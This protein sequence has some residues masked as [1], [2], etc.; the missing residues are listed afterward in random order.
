MTSTLS[1]SDIP[2]T[3]VDALHV[4]A[5]NGDDLNRLSF[6]Q[7]TALRKIYFLDDD[8]TVE[9]LAQAGEIIVSKTDI[10]EIEAGGFK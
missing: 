8:R 9:Q 10:Q 3:R 1:A 7:K 6:E 5:L 4:L 2:I